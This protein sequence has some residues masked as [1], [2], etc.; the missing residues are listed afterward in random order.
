MISCERLFFSGNH[1]SE[2]AKT[3]ILSKG[4]PQSSSRVSA[5]RSPGPTT[6][7]HTRRQAAQRLAQNDDDDDSDTGSESHGS[8]SHL[9][10]AN[11]HCNKDYCPADIEVE[12]IGPEGNDSNSE[13]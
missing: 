11:L 9:G 7:Y 4:A 6:R 2:D 3:H 5:F 12:E 8:E 13:D 1:G 10:R